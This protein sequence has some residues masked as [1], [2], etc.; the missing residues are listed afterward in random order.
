MLLSNVVVSRVT[1]NYPK[2][3]KEKCG[4]EQSDARGVGECTA[5]S[6]LTSLRWFSTAQF[7]LFLGGINLCLCTV[8]KHKD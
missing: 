1:T 7:H 6:E 5:V 8:K 2:E 3:S 4:I